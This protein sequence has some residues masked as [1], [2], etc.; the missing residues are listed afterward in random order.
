[1][2]FVPPPAHRP[3]LSPRAQEL[4]NKIAA[5]IDDYRGY[6]PD[7]TNRD[8]RDALRAATGGGDAAPR[9]PTLVA[10]LLAGVLAALGVFVLRG[11]QGAETPRL[12]APILVAI[13]IAV[14]AAVLAVRRR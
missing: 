3:T 8:V 1:M 13:L 9:T 10:T 12:V 11:Y 6:Y 5:L 7:L 14:F 2:V 4:A